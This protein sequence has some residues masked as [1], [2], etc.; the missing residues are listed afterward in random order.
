MTTLKLDIS[1]IDDNLYNLLLQ[2][3]QKQADKQG[4]DFN[5]I[6]WVAEAHLDE[7]TY[8]ETI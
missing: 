6:H 2:A 1:N 3:F 4:I 5:H 7:E 8:L